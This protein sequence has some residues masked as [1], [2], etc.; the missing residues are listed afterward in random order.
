MS[1]AVL[2]PLG[3]VMENQAISIAAAKNEAP[4]ARTPYAYA[5]YAEYVL[6]S[7]HNMQNM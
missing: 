5:K 4:K 6:S 7:N 2:K 3:P 1:V